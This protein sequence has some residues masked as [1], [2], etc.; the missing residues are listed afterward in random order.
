[1]LSNKGLDVMGMSPS[2]QEN[3]GQSRLD[4][5]DE[6]QRTKARKDRTDRATRLCRRCLSLLIGDLLGRMVVVAVAITSQGGELEECRV[7]A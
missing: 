1:M 6:R 4:R 5:K 7:S 3:V 2:K